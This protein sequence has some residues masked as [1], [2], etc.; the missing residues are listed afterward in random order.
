MLLGYNKVR[1]SRTSLPLDDQPVIPYIV[2]MDA[3]VFQP[4]IGKTLKVSALFLTEC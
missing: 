1:L 4:V 3:I 2:H